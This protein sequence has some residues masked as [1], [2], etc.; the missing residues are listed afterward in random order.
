M[1]KVELTFLD[2]SIKE[3]DAG[4]SAFEV[5]TSISKSLAKSSVVAKLNG[6]Y[7]DLH[8]A[9]NSSSKLELV[10]IESEEALEF[11]RHDTAHLLAQAVKELYPEAQVTIGPAIA[12]GFYYDFAREKPFTEEDLVVIEKK[13]HFL[14]KQNIP[15]KREVWDRDEAVE[16]FKSMGESYKAELIASIPAGE[17]ISL[18]RQGDFIDLCRGPHA[19]STGSCKNFKLTKVSGAYWRG[20][21]NNQMLQRIYGTAWAS[22]EQLDTHLHNLAEAA[23][24][25]HRRLGTELD[26]FHVQEEAAGSVFWHK[27][28]AILYKII[29]DFI[30]QEIEKQDYFQVKTPIL[31][32][33]VLWEK[34]GHWEKFRENMFTV[35]SEDKT[36][37]VKPMNCPAHVQI[38]NQKVRSYRDLPLRMA[39]FGCCHR[40][41]SSGSLHGIMRVRSFVQ[42]D[43][44]IFCTEDQILSETKAF[45]ELVLEVY[46]KFGFEKVKIK[47]SDRPE[48]RA[49]SD[50]VWDKAENALKSA[51]DQ[52]GLE[53]ELNPGEG[54]FYGPK[55]EFVLT[56]VIGRDWQ[57]GTLQVDF[58]LPKRLDAN[59]ISETGDHKK[60]VMLHRAI[61]GSFERF[62]GILIEQYGGA[63]PYWL[64][65]E[66]AAILN[67]TN[68][69]DSYAEE[70]FK[71]LR[72][73]GVRVIKDLSSDKISY[74]VRKY[75]N[76][77]IPYLLIIGEAEQKNRTINLRTLGS[78]AQ[79]TLAIDD[80]VNKMKR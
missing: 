21:S 80:I 35:E 23:K 71:L 5:A 15:I 76:K 74:K 77:K 51:I 26:L 1:S 79:E 61:L 59:Y 27:N 55:I 37:A 66:Q 56:D 11:I 67:I 32:D 70:V 47:F 54:A 24:R 44:H 7:I 20:D 73:K 68:K 10:T 22:K 50:E 40:N 65:P 3:Y 62:I 48:T 16:F 46:K 4:I 12:N 52:I 28:G 60:P 14:S 58:I 17:K 57:C 29:E 78:E 53:Y 75:S 36:L 2:G 45:T 72:E 69:V 41:E 25:D 6:E 42:D 33:R 64:A 9:I 49:G 34:S 43:A 39:E 18:Y 30:A 38:F 8:D 63:F 13:M 31:I 19:R